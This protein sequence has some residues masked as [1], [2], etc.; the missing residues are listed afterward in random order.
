MSIPS[1]VVSTIQFILHR[2][3]DQ[4]DQIRSTLS[5]NTLSPFYWFIE[6][7]IPGRKTMKLAVFGATG[8]IGQW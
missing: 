4:T 1:V 6:V 8:G 7:D 5:I 3:T 2:Q